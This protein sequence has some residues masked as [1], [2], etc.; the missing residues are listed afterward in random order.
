M[1]QLQ[2]AF[3]DGVI[4]GD[5]TTLGDSWRA[6]YGDK[7][8]PKTINAQASRLWRSDTVTAYVDKVNRRKDAQRSRKMAGEV[9]R[10]R[11]HLW[12]VVDGTDVEQP[13]HVASLRLLAQASAML[14]DVKVIKKLH[15]TSPEILEQVQA[16]LD[17]AL[18]IPTLEPLKL[19]DGE[20]INTEASNT[21]SSNT[22]ESS[23]DTDES[24]IESI[25]FP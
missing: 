22:D 12:L 1:N 17:D 15:Q 5:Y 16:L 7:S 3:A 25:D 23:T 19:V 20:S 9:D 8:N 18:G 24:S 13:N 2:K 11:R 10:I 4:D 6:V 21:E 14:V